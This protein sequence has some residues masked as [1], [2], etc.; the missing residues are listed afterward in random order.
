MKLWRWDLSRKKGWRVSWAYE[1]GLWL[2]D[3][4]DF[5]A[6]CICTLF[7]L[8]RFVDRFVSACWGVFEWSSAMFCLFVPWPRPFQ[9]FLDLFGQDGT[10][11][12][13]QVWLA[14]ICFESLKARTTVDYIMSNN[15]EVLSLTEGEFLL[16]TP[17][18]LCDASACL[19]RIL[20]W[21]NKLILDRSSCLP[22]HFKNTLLGNI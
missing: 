19:R 14:A 3:W 21:K 9:Y 22:I 11:P 15:I 8:F 6:N 16:F 12:T 2:V 17:F 13:R 4:G 1:E 10:S 20:G 18:C 5:F 7:R